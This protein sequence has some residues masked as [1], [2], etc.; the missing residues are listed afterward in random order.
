MLWLAIR[1]TDFRSIGDSLAAA[2]RIWAVPFLPT[3]FVFYWL[4][5][6]RWRDLLSPSV[7]A[8]TRD[9]FPSVMIGYAGTAILPLQMGELVRTF[10]VSKKFTLPFS[11]VLSSVAIERIFDLLT[12][13]TLLGVALATG[14]STPE[15]LIK[16]GYVIASVTLAGLLIAIWAAIDTE[17]ALSMAGSLMSWMPDPMSNTI[18]KHL[19]AATRGIASIRNPKLLIQIAA[20]SILQWGLMGLC[21]WFSLLAV[22]IHVPVSGVIL[23]LVATIVGISL[24]ASPG[25]LGSIQLA[26]VV[27]LRPFGIDAAQAVAASVFYHVLAYVAVVVVGFTYAHRLDYGILEIEAEARASTSKQG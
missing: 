21:I 6:A 7:D 4:K 26:F 9:L 8:R 1:G 20:N 3:L 16:A 23:V 24:P 12:I 25:Y 2:E 13:L 10:I 5:S 14:Q 17:G 19:E 18:L 27:A 11:L 15:L 22:D